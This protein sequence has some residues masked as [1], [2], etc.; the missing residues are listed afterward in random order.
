MVHSSWPG[1]F[2]LAQGP[3]CSSKVC[4]FGRKHKERDDWIA[5]RFL[6]HCIHS[7]VGKHEGVGRVLSPSGRE[8]PLSRKILA[9]HSACKGPLRGVGLLRGGQGWRGRWIR[10]V[11]R[12]RRVGADK[13]QGLL[14]NRGQTF[15]FS[16]LF[17]FSNV[18]PNTP[19]FQQFGK[20]Q[21]PL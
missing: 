7:G 2:L 6:V 4:E 19:N 20:Y 13:A 21:D 12:G 9:L 3:T 5:T 15:D 1:L 18:P 11:G 14:E 10:E 8:G 17:C 16:L